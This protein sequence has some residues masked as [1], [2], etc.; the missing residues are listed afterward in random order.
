MA[1]GQFKLPVRPPRQLVLPGPVPAKAALGG[2]KGGEE[3]WAG[4]GWRSK[5]RARPPRP[6][7]LPG[8]APGKAAPGGA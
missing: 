5:P 1:G 7:V 2:A 8:P 4:E 6:L 3:V